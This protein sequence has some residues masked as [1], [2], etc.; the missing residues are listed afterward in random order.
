MTAHDL[1]QR[2]QKLDSIELQYTV[3]VANDTGWLQL[4]DLAIDSALKTID[5]VGD[6]ESEIVEA[7]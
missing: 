3:L 5:L 4:Y 7:L 6:N 2:L 1:L